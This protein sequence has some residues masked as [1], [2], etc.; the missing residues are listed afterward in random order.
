MAQ[1]LERGAARAVVHRDEDRAHARLGLTRRAF[2]AG[3]ADG[4]RT[5]LPP[6]LAG[7]RHV[8]HAQL[9]K[10]Y[11]ANERVHYEVWADSHRGTIEIG[12]HFEDGPASTANYLAYFDAYI[13]E[14]KHLLGTSLELEQWT[15]S[16][17]HLYELLPLTTLDAPLVERVAS[18]LAQLIATLQP[19]VDAAA[20]APERVLLP[21]EER[22]PWRKWRRGRS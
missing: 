6:E 11:Y 18:R 21:R 4:V 20:V 8:A 1:A 10:V 17:G 3:V 13:V 15:P 7:F 5:E 19:L 9:L 14:L 22:G 16:W 12:L 2:F